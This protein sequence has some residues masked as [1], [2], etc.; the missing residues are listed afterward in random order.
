M[1]QGLARAEAATSAAA[2]CLL[3]RRRR[4]IG[5]IVVC[6][7]FL[8]CP[9]TN[10]VL[11]ECGAGPACRPALRDE[12]GAESLDMEA[13]GRSSQDSEGRLGANPANALSRIARGRLGM[14]TSRRSV[15][16]RVSLL[17]DRKQSKSID[18]T[19]AQ[20]CELVGHGCEPPAAPQGFS[21]SRTPR[22]TRD[23]TRRRSEPSH[24]SA[25]RCK[26]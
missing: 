6:G 12:R 1:G 8:G 24:R 5:A 14:R 23:V 25:H 20:S 16:R 4:A 7:P 19:R 11:T 2:S 21:I 3:R 13:S 9:S 10:A 18:Y 22:G 17:G 15:N 26:Q